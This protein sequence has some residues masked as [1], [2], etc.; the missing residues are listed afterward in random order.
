MKKMSAVLFLA[1]AFCLC[2]EVLP[3]IPYYEK[4]APAQT[5]SLVCEDGHLFAVLDGVKTDLLSLLPGSYRGE[6]EK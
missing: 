3:E 2:A 1:A 6:L 4:D 5:V